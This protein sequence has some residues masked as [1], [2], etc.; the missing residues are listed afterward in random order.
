MQFNHVDIH[1][2]IDAQKN[3]SLTVFVGAGFSK[4]SETKSI[5][6]PS[7]SE[8]IIDLQKDLN[9][10]D[11]TDFLKVAQLY[12]LEFGE[13]NLYKKLRK[14]V[15]LHANP[16]EF[17]FKLF[18][19]LKP[20]YVITTNW[21]NLLEK[22]IE[23]NGLMYDT[24]KTESDLIKSNLPQK[25]V[26]IHGDFDSHNIVFKEDDYLNYSINNPLFDNFLKHIISTTT[27][28]FLGYSY[29]DN[30]LKQIIKWIE[31]HSKV[32]P[33]RFLLSKN[34]TSF[35]N[36]YLKNHGIKVLESI[37]IRDF[38]DLYEH[39]FNTIEQI[40]EGLI[41]L[42]DNNSKKFDDTLVIDYFYNKL[43]G[44]SELHTLLPEQ[45]T[46]IF[47]NCTVDYHKNCFGLHFHSTIL[48][49]DFDSNIRK[50]YSCFFDLL[51]KEKEKSEEAR[52]AKI[53]YIISC[54]LDAGIVFI[55]NKDNDYL[56]ISEFIKE[57]RKSYLKEF[58]TFSDKMPKAILNTLIFDFKSENDKVEFFN[59]Y[60]P[61]VTE[62]Q[63]KKRVLVTHDL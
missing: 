9:N 16:S 44:L 19:I 15:P 52:N 37:N 28:L 38:K 48:T 8:L 50:I 25:L 45:I 7:W 61:L 41:I 3:G 63:R 13:F 29:S 20:K 56:N 17:H 11:E 42:P 54:L 51:K 23:A 36:N 34:G 5:K 57:P 39:F 26:K 6:F 60:S 58:I 10:Y 35:Q 32:S 62:A 59:D 55:R 46:N 21:D 40:K 24:I 2:I 1:S 30:D 43:I 14:F 33:P 12:F 47:S 22:T 31:K 27:V 49:T 4:F 18:D 53:K